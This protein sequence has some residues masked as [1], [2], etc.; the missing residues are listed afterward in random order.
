VTGRDLARWRLRNLRLSG[1]PFARPEGAVE[2]LGAVQSQ[3]YAH[4]LWCLGQRTADLDE[5]SAERAFADG[6][7]LRTHV[8]RP[9]WHFVHPADIRW[10]LELTGPRVHAVNAHYY[11][12]HG[13][14]ADLRARGDVLIADALRGGNHLTRKE[15]QA[16]LAGAGI[17]VEGSRLAYVIMSAELNGVVCSGPRRGRQ[18]TYALL[19]ER[20]P[21][22]RAR[23]RDEALAELTMRYFTSHGPATV[24]DFRWWSSLTVS[25]IGR[26]LE[27]AGARLASETIDGR[28]YRFA[29][30]PPPGPPGAG[31]GGPPTAHLLQ[32][33]DEYIVGYSES[34]YAALDV[35]GAA[36]SN[37]AVFT[38]VVVLDGQVAGWWRR[39]AGKGA[40]TVDVALFERPDASVRAAL[41]AAGKRYEA[42]LGVPVR[43]TIG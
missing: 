35:S 7:L 24:A 25:N 32:P 8:L 30:S 41:E 42:F 23:T 33:Y 22:A 15:L 18:H 3:E 29:G 14:D 12:Q 6:S 20:V 1:P 13:L 21:P 19:D 2:W 26:G 17:E 28:T 5:D 36:R 16:V 43:L 39:T 27:L 34:R 4:A 37:E 11:R 9:T 40:M 31:G 38:A 10:L